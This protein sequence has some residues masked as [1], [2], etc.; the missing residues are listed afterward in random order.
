MFQ[1]TSDCL[2][3]IKQIDDEHRH[4]FDLINEALDTLRRTSFLDQYEDI[5]ELLYELDE[6][7]DQHFAHEE[8]YMA[9]ICDPELILQRSQHMSFRDAIS[10]FSLVNID[11]EEDQVSM[12]QELLEFLAK[13]LYRHILGSDIMIGKLPPL[14]KWMIQENPCEF[15]AE[16]LTGIPLIDAEHKELFAIVDKANRLARAQDLENS[17]NDIHSVLQELEVYTR[18]HFRDEEEYMESIHYEGLEAQ[19]RAHDA[20]IDKLENISLKEHKENPHEYMQSLLS[21]LLGWL[22]NH[23][24]LVDKKIPYY[25]EEW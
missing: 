21:F 16:Y 6:Y 24:I 12:M 25:K 14:E 5:K 8:A 15:T 20:F 9:K 1:F 2:L 7:A 17:Y 22:V 4:L 13:W 23:I 19:K 18:E 10:R 11:Q 3:G